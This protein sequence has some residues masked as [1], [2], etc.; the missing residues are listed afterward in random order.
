MPY[1]RNLV[2][3]H[4]NFLQARSDFETIKAKLAVRAPDIE[5]FI[6]NNDIPN[7]VTRRR[8]ATRPTLVFSPVA[9]RQFRPLR[10]KIL[11]GRN[12]RKWGEYLAMR[13]A[14]ISTPNTVLLERDT[15]IDPREWGPFTVV[16]PSP[17]MQGQGVRLQR[18]R[19]VRWVDT[20]TLPRGDPRKDAI[21]LA[22]QFVDTGPRTAC[23][24]VLTVLGA[25]AY[26][27]R[28]QAVEPR[29]FTVDPNGSDPI[30]E[31]IAA[32]VSARRLELVN[33]REIIEFGTGVQRAFPDVPV[34]GVDVIREEATG[35]L[36]ALEVNAPG[37]TW[38]L[39]SNYGL[40]LQRRHGIDLYSQ[41]DA[42]EV[43]A[44]A[45]VAAT[46]REAE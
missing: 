43:I 22:Q 24:R 36:F 6:V 4:S 32:N 17:G 18:T 9:L 33:D 39:S 5:V 16:K 27:L 15:V 40:D 1:E 12:P 26:C 10:G 20:R 21:L 3:V 42:L 34:L 19:D 46:R 29:P 38:S 11:A 45:M 23:Y 41:F 31:P 7:S 14:G 30:D 37:M 35:K 44:D 13:S 28:S 8:A 2:L 25:A